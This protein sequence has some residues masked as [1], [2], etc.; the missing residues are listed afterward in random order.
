MRTKPVE[1]IHVHVGRQVKLLF[2]SSTTWTAIVLP[3]VAYFLALHRHLL[4]VQGQFQTL[5]RQ[6]LIL[7]IMIT[8]NGW[9]V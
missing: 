4:L 3:V 2:A 1:T 5:L 9:Q 7:I 8:I 6:Q